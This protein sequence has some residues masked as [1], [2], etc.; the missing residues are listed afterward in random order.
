MSLRGRIFEGK[1]VELDSRSLTVGGSWQ[2]KLV[3]GAVNAHSR[4]LLEL[5][6]AEMLKFNEPNILDIGA[7]T[8]SFSLLLVHH[9]GAAVV[10]FEPNPA[11]YE[12]LVS[13]LELNGLT[14]SLRA[15]AVEAAVTSKKGSRILRVPS[16]ADL[17]GLASMGHV[18]LRFS[19]HDEVSVWCTTIDR[20]I[21]ES[22]GRIH[23]IKIDTEGCELKVLL[24]GERTIRCCRPV[25]FTEY[26]ETNC[27]QFGYKHTE[28]RD[29]LDSWGATTEKITDEDLMAYWED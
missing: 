12:V 26:H 22:Y 6:Y 28:V 19:D 25:I 23:M 5:F 16:A 15:T 27:A 24:G 1:L 9:P 14:D 7:S 20:A 11:V 4:R 10:A 3:D 21:H 8:G 29:L 17:S 18:P 2:T 13:N